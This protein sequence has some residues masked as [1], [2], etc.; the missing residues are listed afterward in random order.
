[1]TQAHQDPD[2]VNPSAAPVVFLVDDD[3][4]VRDAIGLLLKA[5]GLEVRAFASAESFLESHRPHMA[6]CLLLDVRMPG[7]SGLM[8]QDTMVANRM[9]LPIIFITAHGNVPTAVN[10]IKKGAVQF[11]E[12]P[13]DDERLLALVHEAL[14]L[15]AQTRREA[16]AGASI[17]ARV[18]SLTRRERQVLDKVLAGKTSREIAVE[19]FISVKTV[20]FHR[21]RIMQ[22]LEISSLREL[23]PI[24]SYLDNRADPESA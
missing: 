14:A 20:D 24:L 3:E 4:A 6:G 11:I 18:D 16:A 10:A 22:K 19:L 5:S 15:D 23:F 12:K 1:M 8:L 21:G 9:S 7:M 17:E 2:G 13:F